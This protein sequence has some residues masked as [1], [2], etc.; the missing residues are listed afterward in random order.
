MKLDSVDL[1]AL[2]KA[3]E[4]AG[5]VAA[6]E[7]AAQLAAAAHDGGE[8][9]QMLASRENGK[10]LAW[11]T[12]RTA[13]CELDVIVDPGVYVPRWQTEPLARLAAR[14]L[15]P[16]GVGVDIC[17]GT[18]VVA[19]VMQSARPD[20]RIVATEIDPLAAA[21]A[22]RNGVVVYQGDLDKPLPADLTGQVDVMTGV[23]P[24]VPADALRLLPRDV[25]RFEP[26]RALD[27]G[28]AGLELISQLV[29]RSGRWIKRGGFL[30][31]EAGGDQVPEVTSMLGASGYDGIEVLIDDD[32]DPRG[33][34]GCLERRGWQPAAP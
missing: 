31:L 15:T 27:G 6:G 12:G 4:V 17:T 5:C 10:P 18:G 7:E 21:C 19:M 11:I 25:Q 2:T 3:L 28:R 22:R 9:R 30:L 29:G 34:A 23:L 33:I 20:A 26:R 32:G 24:Y 14:L 13:F 1:A 16:E 8:L